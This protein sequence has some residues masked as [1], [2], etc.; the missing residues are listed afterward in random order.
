ML[1]RLEL[2]RLDKI[3]R[4]LVEKKQ[5]EAEMGLKARRWTLCFHSWAFPIW[6]N[7][8]SECFRFFW[9]AGCKSCQEERK[10]VKEVTPFGRVM[11]HLRFHQ[12]ECLGARFEKRRLS[13]V[14]TLVIVPRKFFWASRFCTVFQTFRWPEQSADEWPLPI[15]SLWFKLWNAMAEAHAHSLKKLRRTKAIRMTASKVERHKL[16]QQPL[17]PLRLSP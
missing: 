10:E 6:L 3:E 4:L 1:V 5:T 9:S 13:H 2:P 16:A 14:G 8:V 17:S 7:W 12:D 11:C 15:L